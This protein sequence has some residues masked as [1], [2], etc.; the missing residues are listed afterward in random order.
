MAKVWFDDVEAWSGEIPDSGIVVDEDGVKA[1]R[2]LPGVKTS[3][4]ARE[5]GDGSFPVR[6]SD[7]VYSDRTVT[8]SCAI[9]AGSRPEAVAL[10]TRLNGLN[11]RVVKVRVQDVD[12]TFVTGWIE[13]AFPSE[14]SYEWVP[15]SVTVA[16]AD[17][18]RYSTELQK[19]T[20]TAGARRGAFQY[21]VR[22]PINY[23]D[24]T[25]QVSPSGAVWNRGNTTSWPVVT[26]YGNLVG[27]FLLMDGRG[28]AL[29]FDGDVF[30]ASPV[31]VDCGKRVVSVQGVN[32]TWALSR[33]EWFDVD[34]GGDLT[35]T[36]QPQKDVTVGEAWAELSARDTW[37]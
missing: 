35:V 29:Q 9:M 3:L 24:S 23:I 20:L 14:W 2:D 21:P 15:F 31:R 18:V 16:A 5:G 1:W 10:M 27:G 25:S 6:D 11:H 36:F 37:I 12:D 28:R 33:R 7:V 32:V 34:P 19:V 4:E 17:P 26:V 13:T 8:F 30:P 22:Y